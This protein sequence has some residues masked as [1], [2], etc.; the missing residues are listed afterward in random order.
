MDAVE[1]EVA[2]NRVEGVAEEMGRVLVR[3][4]FSPNIKEREDCSTALF[5]ADGRMAAQA[6]H[7]PV[8]LGA[9]PDSVAAV[10]GR[11]VEAGDVWMLNDPYR[12]GS[13]LPDVT[14]VSPVYVDGSHVGYAASRA[15]HADVGGST[16]GSMP[17]DSTSIHEEG[18][19]IPPVR[20]VRDGAVVDDVFD[21]F[22]ANVRAPDERRADVEAQIAANRRGVDRLRELSGELDLGTAFDE[23]IEY[24]R[25]RMRS[26]IERLDDGVYAAEDLLELPDGDVTVA[27]E[28]EVEG[29]EMTFDFEGTSDEVD[30]NL[31]APPSVTRSAVY[32]VLRCLASGDVPVNHGCYA[33]VDVSV[34]EG[35]LLDPNPPAAVAAG[36]VETGQRVADVVMEALRPASDSLPAQ[37]Q[38]TMNNTTV[39]TE[40]FAYYETVGGGQGASSRGP[41]PTGVHVGMSNT[42]NTPVEA[43][44]RDYPLEVAEYAVRRRSGGEGRQRGGDGLVRSI[45][46][47]EDARVSLISGRRRRRPRGAEG[48]G[49]GARGRNLVDGEEVAGKYVGRL[50][51]GSVVT[52]VSP[53]GG[54]WG[55]VGDSEDGGASGDGRASDVEAD[56]TDGPREDGLEEGR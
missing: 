12:G 17:A 5:T 15:H 6:E 28:I 4:A 48:G 3:T 14:L 23:V 46:L 45:R 25:E 39:G 35:S 11:E 52:V 54:G 21:V 49:D 56:A 40:E 32:F 44:E 26:E 51:A 18:L 37:G 42:L 22:L 27:V 9:M 50:D 8:H 7:I 13:H 19:R 20:L 29:H 53:G 36:N 38:G 43:L 55:A 16:P 33:D 1:L 30:G 31:N 34:P 47:L 24:A 2:R 10:A 41:G